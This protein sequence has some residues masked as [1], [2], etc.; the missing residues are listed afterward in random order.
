M[1]I[2]NTVNHATSTLQAHQTQQNMQALQKD[3]QGAD[4]AKALE[5][6]KQFEGM[7]ITQMFGQMFSQLETDGYFGGGSQEKMFQSFMVEEYGKLMV[8]RGGIGLSD[9]IHKQM[10]M[11]QEGQ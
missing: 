6:A 9:E 10:I 3:I 7:F 2:A 1:D 4:R 11:M 8:D 5:A